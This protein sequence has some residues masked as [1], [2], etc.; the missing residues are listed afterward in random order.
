V[1]DPK[2]KRTRRRRRNRTAARWRLG[3]W[4]RV[5]VTVTNRSAYK[6]RRARHF[7]R[8]VPKKEAVPHRDTHLSSLFPFG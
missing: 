5:C 3:G 2:V 6:C 8:A 1:R 4:F 7:E